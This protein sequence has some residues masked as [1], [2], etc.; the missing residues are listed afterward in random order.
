MKSRA[1]MH[2]TL[3]EQELKELLAFYKTALG[4]KLLVE[5]PIAIDDGIRRAREWAD[6]F[7]D[8]ISIG[9]GPK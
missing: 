4:K 5:E 3:R 6:A 7:S 1:P 2:V 9:C 8:Q